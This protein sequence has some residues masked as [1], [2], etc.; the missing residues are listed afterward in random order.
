VPRF[1]AQD[2]QRE[3]E[4]KLELARAYDEMGDREGARELLEEVVKDGSAE[5]REEAE[6]M[7]ERLA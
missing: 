2:V 5:Q 3:M 6:R 1:D 4:T 7:L